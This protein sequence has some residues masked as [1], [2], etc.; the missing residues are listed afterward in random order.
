MLNRN[1]E[2]SLLSA[3]LDYAARLIGRS[4]CSLHQRTYYVFRALYRETSALETRP[5]LLRRATAEVVDY[6]RRSVH[7]QSSSSLEKWQ[8]KKRNCN[9]D[10]Q[11]QQQKQKESLEELLSIVV[12]VLG[13]Y[14]DN[15]RCS[16][17]SFAPLTA[18]LQELGL[19]RDQHLVS[20][21]A[22]S[23][24]EAKLMRRAVCAEEHSSDEDKDGGGKFKYEYE[25]ED[26]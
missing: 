13:L 24:A 16:S 3:L 7:C 8:K 9:Q 21:F 25:V 17:A 18:A 19:V 2:P 20:L 10:Q 5:Y 11:P 26:D 1:P 6:I 15:P 23:P 12:N 4:G 22:F 14:I